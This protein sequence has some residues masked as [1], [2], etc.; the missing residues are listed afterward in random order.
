MF[1]EHPADRTAAVKHAAIVAR[2]G[3][4]LVALLGI[5]DERA[6][7]RGLQGLGILLEPADQVFGDEGRCF[8][9]QE[10]ITVDE[11]EYLDGRSSNRLRRISR[12][13]GKSRPRRR[14]RLISAMVL[15]SR[16]FLPQST[17]MQPI[18]ASVG[19]ALSASSSLR[20]LMTSKPDRLISSTI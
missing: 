6:E 11:I 4:Q 12:M 14:I 8:L 7:E 2:A 20:A 10:D 16:P 18:A 17:T 3:P 5:V 1:H 19:T 9:G 13:I 15:P